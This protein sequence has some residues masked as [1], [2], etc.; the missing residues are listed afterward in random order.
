MNCLDVCCLPFIYIYRC[1]IWMCPCMFNIRYSSYEPFDIQLQNNRCREGGWFTDDY[2]SLVSTR[3]TFYTLIALRLRNKGGKETFAFVKRLSKTLT[4]DGQVASGF[5]YHWL[6]NQP[7]Y[8]D[9]NSHQMSVDANIMFIIMVWWSVEHHH[10]QLHKYYLHCQRAM[11]W[12]DTFT[13]NHIL[14]EPVGASWEYTRKHDGKLLLT[15][16][17]MTQAIRSL[18]LIAC[19]MKDK[20]LEEM[21]RDRHRHYV[22][23]WQ[24]EVYK[25]QETLPRIL[26]VYWNMVPK[27]FMSSFNQE[28]HTPHVPLRTSGPIKAASMM[29]DRV[30]GRGDLHQT[31]VWPWV[32]FLWVAILAS[33]GEKVMARR[34]W[35]AYI[36]MHHAK[37]L[38]DIYDRDSG[39]PIRRAFLKAMPAHSLTIAMQMA[40]NQLLTGL[41]VNV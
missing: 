36:E 7:I 15:N 14:H 33:R 29:R 41:P 28:I 37:T 11:H 27:I 13:H 26:A 24:N 10:E 6:S 18:E 17:L 39:L 2:K 21:Y 22:S 23:K 5:T 4:A 38:Y 3:D 35:T 30:Y 34:W 19:T 32:G 31:V 40:A 25:T 20:R 12:L 8:V 9:N 1:I 16:V